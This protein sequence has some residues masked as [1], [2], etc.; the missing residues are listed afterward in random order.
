M[1]KTTLIRSN[2]KKVD[3]SGTSAITITHIRWDPQMPEGHID[4]EWELGSKEELLTIAVQFLQWLDEAAKNTGV[5][6]NAIHQFA[7]ESGRLEPGGG[8]RLRYK[9][10]EHPNAQV[11]LENN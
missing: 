10:A 4:I 3:K 5:V 1:P 11:K 6:E 7:I 2:G 9:S 8:V